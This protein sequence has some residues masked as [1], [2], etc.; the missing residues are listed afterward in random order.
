MDMSTSLDRPSLQGIWLPLIT[1]FTDG[2][3]DEAAL[4]ALARHY[5]QAPIDG[6]ILAATT[7]EALTLD[8]GELDQR[9]FLDLTG[10]R[11]AAQVSL[12]A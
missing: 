10:L 1:P 11:L 7:G 3:L 8:D 9:A 2:A 4:G 5:T 6:F 12:R